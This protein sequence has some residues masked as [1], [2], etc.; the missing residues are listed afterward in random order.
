MERGGKK[1]VRSA[2]KASVKPTEKN[3][4]DRGGEP[5]RP[6]GRKFLSERPM[7]RDVSLKRKQ[8]HPARSTGGVGP[9][10]SGIQPHWQGEVYFRSPPGG[11]R[12]GSQRKGDRGRAGEMEWPTS[13]I[14]MAGHG[15]RYWGSIKI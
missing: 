6:D 4:S 14:L 7:G 8:A 9:P 2:S 10:G 3:L 12:E 13:S 5:W 11:M 1:K 15:E